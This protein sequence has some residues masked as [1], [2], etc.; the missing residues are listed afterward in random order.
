[1]DTINSLESCWQSEY[2]EEIWSLLQYHLKNF[3]LSKESLNT[4][5]NY[6]L[7]NPNGGYLLLSVEEKEKNILLA[8]FIQE[9]KDK[10]I[11]LVYLIRQDK[12][13]YRILQFLIWQASEFFDQILPRNFF[14]NDLNSLSRNLVNVLETLQKE[15]GKIIIIID[16]LSAVSF[17]NI[18][19]SLPIKL[20]NNI[21]FI[22]LSKPDLYLTSLLSE[23]LTNLTIKNLETTINNNLL[24]NI[25]LE[26]VDSKLTVE[27]INLILS[28]LALSYEPITINQLYEIL[29]ISEI[30]ID[31]LEIVNFI[32]KSNKYFILTP[33]NK[34]IFVNQ[35]ITNHINKEILT[36]EKQFIYYQYFV[37]WLTLT[38]EKN[39]N[40]YFIYFDNYLLKTI[41]LSIEL[42][43][44]GATKQLF[45]EATNEF[46]NIEF[47]IN[48]LNLGLEWQFIDNLE[49]LLAIKTDGYLL[50]KT[51]LQ[52]CYKFLSS[53]LQFISTYPERFL[54]QAI[55]QPTESLISKAASI[56]L[57]KLTDNQ[58][59]NYIKWLNKPEKVIYNSL[60]QTLIKRTTGFQA[61]KLTTDNRFLVTAGEDSQIRVW[62]LNTGQEIFS[63]TDH[64]GMIFSLSVSKDNRYIISGDSK[65][66]INIWE[67]FTGKLLSSLKE[68]SGSVL[69]LAVTSDN[70]K[71]VSASSDRTIK[72]WDFNLI[73]DKSSCPSSIYTLTEHKTI[74]NKLTISL[75]DK[76][77]ISGGSDGTIKVWDLLSYLPI[78]D[79][80]AHDYS[81]TGLNITSDNK[82]LIS[83]SEDAKIKVWEL[84]TSSLIAVLTES[85]SSINT[86]ALTKD[87]QYI[88]TGNSDKTINIWNLETGFLVNVLAGHSDLITDL[89][90]SEG[91][92][93]STSK[94]GTVKLWN[95][96][97]AKENTA[98]I[99]QKF[100]I[101]AVAISLD[102]RYAF[103]GEI[104]GTIRI[105][106][107][108]GQEI[109]SL[110]AHSASVNAMA[111]S[112]DKKY[113]VSAS[114]NEI[115][116]W[117]LVTLECIDILTEH[118][119]RVL[120][121]IITP[122]NKYIISS[123]DDRT[124]KIWDL[125][126]RKLDT[127]LRDRAGIYALVLMENG[128]EFISANFAGRIRS[129]D[130]IK[131]HV[132]KEQKGC[133]DT[134]TAITS[135]NKYQVIGLDENTLAVVN[136][137][138]E[139]IT[140]TFPMAGSITRCAISDTGL[141]ISCDQLGNL[142]F[143]QLETC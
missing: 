30:K 82:Y 56:Y 58:P 119:D 2:L 48:K 9:Q 50:D 125:A 89:A 75:D 134:K 123:S 88:V 24:D 102:G 42:S 67:L 46:T 111:V 34:I 66:K 76:Y 110:L 15:K 109:T 105:W 31:K 70:T 95:F 73:L 10:N 122:D 26:I 124:I 33:N 118:Q 142:Y 20:P 44:F 120:S 106:N 87:N 98:P 114:G 11:C 141:I 91:T 27:E 79:F 115:K 61:L 99:K 104:N 139:I 36:K 137:T 6:L 40:N 45:N 143:L 51:N 74:V 37:K 116:L 113:L 55:N 80:F 107:H 64:Q 3:P 62:E 23:R 1:M 112:V 13:P 121:L 22:L 59:Y 133:I 12:N 92:I 19:K 117:D 21:Y 83:T 32:I 93:F 63:L 17:N 18:I 43:Y 35:E 38:K 65:G 128:K 101:S 68:H 16:N 29:E 14:Y 103:S 130:L 4:L 127:T 132:V 5:E 78:N 94:D 77:L 47:I 138:E 126:S 41:L 97:I 49:Q 96:D 100:N 57:K 84:E 85:T 52:I 136:L 90:L 8:K 135:N 25:Y 54:Q 69:A 86:L 131:K 28:L 81:V 71:L 60:K 140:G 53:Q 72:V 7:D 108:L 129:W 39:Q